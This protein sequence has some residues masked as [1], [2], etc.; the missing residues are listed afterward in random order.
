MGLSKQAHSSFE[1]SAFSP[2][3]AHAKQSASLAGTLSNTDVVANAAYS[4]AFANSTAH[5]K[6]HLAQSKVAKPPERESGSK[7][8]AARTWTS[9][10]YVDLAEQTWLSFPVEDYMRK[11]NKTLLEVREV[12]M[13]IVRLPA[14]AQAQRGVGLPRGGLGEERMKEFRKM[15]K[16]AI[17]ASREEADREEKQEKGRR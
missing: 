15:E 13:G 16:E 9:R 7:R 12:F 17:Q 2:A 8:W 3:Y 4:S 1:G 10:Q 14:L 5:P 11:H 6:E